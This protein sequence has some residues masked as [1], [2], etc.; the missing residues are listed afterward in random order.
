MMEVNLFGSHDYSQEELCAES[1]AAF[2]CAVIGIQTQRTITNT[3][4]YVKGWL[5]A[6]KNDRKLL[7]HGIQN[8]QKAADYILGRKVEYKEDV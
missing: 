2:L 8:G 6:L 5:E 3:K 1:C 4:A 7:I